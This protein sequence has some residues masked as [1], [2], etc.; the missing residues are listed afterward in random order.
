MIIELRLYPPQLRFF[1]SPGGVRVQGQASELEK[2]PQHEA[3]QL[4]D[5]V[6]HEAEMVRVLPLDELLNQEAALNWGLPL[7][8]D[9]ALIKIDVEGMEVEVVK[10]ALSFIDHFKPI[11]WAE[12]NAY[13]D[14]G[15]KD[16][17]FLEALARVGYQCARADS[18]PG[19]VICTDASGRGHQIP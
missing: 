19:D 3:F 18:A 7:L 6:S 8:Q 12:N 17:A 14:S 2:K 1:S 10:G 5:L 11:I 4:Y 16:T 9:V 13:F 15:G